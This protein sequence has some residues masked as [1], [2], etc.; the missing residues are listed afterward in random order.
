MIDIGRLRNRDETLDTFYH[1]RVLVLQK[2]RGYRFAVDS[3]LLADFIQTQP[4]DEL[5]ELGCGCGIISLLLSQKAFHHITCLEIQPSL[6]DLA[7]RNVILNQLEEK[8]TVIE[9]DLKAYSPGRK[10]DVI[11]SNPPYFK[12][13]TGWV[14]QITEKA[15]ARHE[16]MV[17]AVS[18]VD[19]TRELLKPE[20]RCYFIYRANRYSEIV[21]LMRSKGLF[22]WRIR[23]V[24]P[25]QE[26]PPRFF[27]IEAGLAERVVEELTPLVLFEANGE[28]SPEARRILAGE[29]R[30]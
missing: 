4:S 21:K 1:G 2:R 17:D 5:L 10:F 14:S 22:P 6:A 29:S 11:F 9:T 18:L 8:I 16:I 12:Q 24:Y 7:R 25:R 19:K 30:A 15:I 13:A 20:G 28:Y 26:K 23:W 3:A 27:L